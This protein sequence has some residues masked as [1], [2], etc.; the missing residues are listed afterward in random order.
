MI[1]DRQAR[2]GPD[3]G[4][5]P[6]RTRDVLAPSYAS[7]ALVGWT[8]ALVPSLLRVIKGDFGQDDAGIG[9]LYLV[10]ALL[11]ASGAFLVGMLA[12]RVGRRTLLVGSALVLAAGLLT[13][14][15]A[16]AWPVMLAG[17]ALAGGGGGAIDAAVNGAIMDLAATGR[18]SALNRLHLFYSVGSL[19]API[20]VG[21]LV[22]AGVDWR[23]A[24]GVT[25]VAALAI[26]LPIRAIGAVPARAHSTHAAGDGRDPGE[27][28]RRLPVG[29]DFRIPLATLGIA[30]T[31]LVATEMGVSSWLVGFLADE[32]MSVATL[33]LGLF[34][35]GH[36]SGRLVAGRFADRF[37]PVALAVAC[38]LFS[39]V[40]LLAAVVG[41]RGAVQLA[42]FTAVGF[43]IGPTYPMIMTVAATLY[44]HR[45]AKVSGLLTAAGVGGS[46]IY[47]PLMGFVSGTAGLG[48][49]MLGAAGLAIVSGTAIAVAGRGARRRRPEPGQPVGPVR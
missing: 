30:I 14:A 34:W 45:A 1:P 22:D 16:P 37:H 48:A 2:S 38:V 47:P 28:A 42:L 40:A 32:P 4:G 35:A 6:A 23:V 39:G 7:F 24:I 10:S 5:A 49:G 25:G 11:F 3:H 41:P 31:C 20:V 12:E 18:G 27:D 17:V 43:G 21:S 26:V 46:V 15:M 44:P 36:A 29:P 8:M 13:E 9:L 33:A 19:A